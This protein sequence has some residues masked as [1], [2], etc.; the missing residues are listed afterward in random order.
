MVLILCPSSASAQR[1]S[2]D[3]DGSRLNSGTF[4]GLELRNTGPAFMSGRIADVV[5]NPHDRSVWY[6]AV[7]S[8]NVWK[9]VNAGTTWKPI[10]DNYGS[11]SMGCIALDPN[12]PEVVWLG[13]GENASQRSAGYGDGV[14]KSL[15]GGISW[16][17]VGLKSSEHIGKILIDP[18]DSDVVYVAAQGPL[19]AP[20]GDRGLY[21]TTDGGASWELVLDIGE[22]TG[23]TDIAFET[24]NPDIIYAASYQRRRHVGIL[25]AGGPESAIYK[26]SDAGATWKK[27]TRGI[28]KVDMGR[29]ALAVSP[30]KPNVVYALIAAVDGKSGFFRSPDR[31]EHW[32]KMGDYIVVDPQYYGEIYADPHKFDRVYAMDV[33]IHYTEDGG[34]TFQRLGSQYKHVDNHAM[35]FDPDDPEY[36]MV[37][38]D[39][40]L[41]ESWD[42]GDTWKAIQN[43]SITQFYRV[44][45]DN[46]TPFY[47]VYGGTQDNSTLG[48][49][50]RTKKV[51]G[52]TNADWFITIG[53]DGFQTRV[54]P[55]NPDILYSQYQYAGIV[56]YDK[57]SGE[58][59]EIQPQS[60]PGGSALRW[61][62]DSPLV[63]S[64]FSN[65]RLYFA[66]NILFR[67]DDRGDTWV[68]VSPDLSRGLD[69]NQM[70]VMGTVWS[71]DAVWK[72]VFTSPFGTIV[73]LDES[74]LVEGL[75]YVGTDDGLI[76]VTEDGG[77]NWRKI[78]SF[79]GVPDMT[80]V[81]DV[82]ASRH[83]EN[84][85]YAVFNNHKSGDFKPYVLKSTD[86]GGSW[87]AITG[88]IPERHVTWTIAEDH[89]NAGLLFVGTELGLFFTI[90]GGGE[91]IQLKGGVPT[92]AF[93]DLEIQRRENDLVGATFGRGFYI[94]DDYSPLRHVSAELLEG[95][96]SLFPV[97]DP[98]M[99]IESG[100]MGYSEKGSQGAAFFTAPNPPFGAVFTYYLR[101]AL[102][103][104]RQQRQA[105]EAQL[106]REGEPV[107]YP[108]WDELQR[109]DRADDPAVIL[110]VS[111][112]DGNVV[113]RITGRTSAGMHRIAW[114]LRYP[115]FAPTRRGRE[116][117][118]PMVVPGR[119]TVR[120]AKMVDGV[121][122]A[123]G[124]PRSFEAKPLGLATLAASDKAA[125]LVFQKKVGRLQRAVLGADR[126]VEETLEQLG[127]VELAL[128]NTPAA[129][130]SLFEQVRD[131]KERLYDIDEQLTGDITQSSR[132]E[133]TAPGITQR[134]QRIVENFWSS[135]APTT[136]N[137]QNYEIAGRAFQQVLEELRVLVDVDMAG[138]GE[139]LE[140]I[141]APWT[142]GRGVPSWTFE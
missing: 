13:T 98:W 38:S 36:L 86:R 85:V 45:I 140:A 130:V 101:D 115:A 129:D 138:L 54:D 124:E 41:Y 30:Q 52:I 42:R 58:R 81:A 31:G 74:P 43:L 113:R 2:G 91:W 111:D 24:G 125:L 128:L 55:E 92:V 15:D 8:G 80:Y 100:P 105:G 76:Q 6:M 21:K 53:G 66:A 25:V 123:M 106:R 87:R 141:G 122:T 116:S 139:R 51:H 48:G 3:G 84:T 47:N 134:V 89:E 112:E 49:P 88:N 68:A 107:R 59:T 39:G 9:T 137:Q 82:A 23:V 142:P 28:P 96:T 50:S 61:H 57:R 99:Y 11:Y 14:Y 94:L 117:S 32:V 119:Y 108:S 69:R 118:G 33:M 102:K 79:P 60:G 70:E 27:L 110:S 22:N 46:A 83:D 75:I 12:N 126:V 16:T 95:E 5:K 71:P 120:L 17:N 131:L 40:G 73:S 20:G 93:R 104:Q 19:W 103:S 56:R 1:S 67:S 132:A 26:S 62:W 4:S 109:E 10:F 97:K 65:T 18:R 63:I 78:D 44:G 72:N 77:A 29:I 35:L 136:T 133:F 90:D 37:G 127:F 7:S 114:D 64:P 34:R 121:F 135:S